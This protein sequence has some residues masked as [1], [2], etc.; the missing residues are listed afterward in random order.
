MKQEQ[1]LKG[2]HIFL[3]IVSFLGWMISAIDASLFFFVGPYLMEEFDFSLQTFGMIVAGG[4]LIAIVFSFFI[5]PL[6]DYF[7]RKIVFQWILIFMTIG[8]FLSGLSWNVESLIIFRLLAT[9]SAFA[10]YAVGATILVES[11]PAKHRG[12]LV[13]IMAAGW[14]AGTALSTLISLYVI[15]TL[16]WQS[17]FFIASIPAFIVIVIRLYIKEPKRFRDVIRIRTQSSNRAADS[18]LSEIKIN[19]KVNKEEAVKY[20]LRQLFRG[21]L[22]KNTILIWIYMNAVVISYSLLIWFAPYW[23]NDAFGI[24]SAQA[25][26]TS[27]IGSLVSILGF[28][29]CG[30]LSG[31][32]GIREANTIFIPIGVFITIW[33]TQFANSYSAF[34][35]AYLLWNFF[36]AGIWGVI[37]RLFTEAFPTRARGTGASVN[38]ASC[39]LG[40]AFTS[41]FSPYIIN[42]IGYNKAIFFAGV[43]LFPIALIS[44]WM[45]RRIPPSSDL[46]E[47]IT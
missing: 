40:W 36:G 26:W 41:N 44:L 7:G 9:G 30:W 29:S 2:Y 13:G 5:G 32:I 8:T 14:P 1:Q 37:P 11:V 43:F 31:K 38:S 19:Y 12:W 28:I 47:Y 21:E 3:A 6:M 4:F 10:E 25:T 45:I 42:H 20:P 18:A 17:A 39:W 15:P 22:L 27:C 24:D 23:L 16:G 33:M 46:E 35:P 34:L